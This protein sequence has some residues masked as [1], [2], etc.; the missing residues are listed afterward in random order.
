MTE[1]IVLFSALLVLMFVSARLQEAALLR[2]TRMIDAV[3]DIVSNDDISDCAKEIAV[4]MFENSLKPLEPLAIMMRLLFLS[5]AKGWTRN[6][7]KTDI[8]AIAKLM[9]QH[10]L[11]VNFIAAFPAYLVAGIFILVIVSIYA[12]FKKLTGINKAHYKHR[13]TDALAA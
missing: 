8:E 6:A 1:L 13:V 12:L 2:R 5:D 10:F 11:P 7:T 9:Q 3:A 4:L